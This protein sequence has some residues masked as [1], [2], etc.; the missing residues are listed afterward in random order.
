ML[1]L[2]VWLLWRHWNLGG[3]WS[4]LGANIALACVC[5]LG[6]LLGFLK[7]SIKW[8][9]HSSLLCRKE[10]PCPSY[11]FALFFCIC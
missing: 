2:R 4:F 9:L 11:E 8:G 5:K 7:H 6:V 3:L 10:N 1:S